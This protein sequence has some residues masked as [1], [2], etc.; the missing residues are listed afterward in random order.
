V[1]HQFIEGSYRETNLTNESTEYLARREEL[2][3]AE[4]ALMEQQERIAAMRRA[5]PLGAVIAAY[6][7][8][9]GP[10][11]LNSGDEPVRQI[12]LSELSSAEERPLVI[13]HMMYG[14]KQSIP[15][16]MCTLWVDGFNGVAH[17]LAQSIDFAVVM[18][19]DLPA[20]RTFA[21]TR[22][23]NHLRLLSAASSSFK[24]DF[25]SEDTEG[26]QDS[27]VSV[28]AKDKEGVLRHCYTAHPRMSPEIKERGIDLL[29]PVWNTL[30]LTPL[31]RGKWYPK[32]AYE[33]E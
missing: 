9:E 18:A 24:F 16:P 23:W 5:L 13:Y 2:R 20:I 26:A 28:F 7:F 4:I 32:V 17:H 6:E 15:C 14:K 8:T 31:G 33:K 29:T 1:V 25:G 10:A 22:E 11:D 3:L 30:D 21:R 19:A 12:R 27:T